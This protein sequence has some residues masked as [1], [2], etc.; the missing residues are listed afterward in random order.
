L[1]NKVLKTESP[2]TFPI[3]R[4]WFAEGTATQPIISQLIHRF[5]LHI[6]ILQANV[7]YIK[8]HAIGL[9]IIGM[10]GNKDLFTP[11]IHYLKTAGIHVEVLGYV[12]DTI[13]SFH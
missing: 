12:P 5:Q 13:I 1:E 3:L 7:D 10:Q 11:A 2:G 8:N 4:L 6:N 9:M